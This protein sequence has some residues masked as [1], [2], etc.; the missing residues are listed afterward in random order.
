MRASCF[1][2]AEYPLCQD[3]L[4]LVFGYVEEVEGEVPG[5]VPA[6]EKVGEVADLSGP[7]AS[8]GV[9]SYSASSLTALWLS[10]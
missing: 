6:G 4:A 7:V 10:S 1:S 2:Q 3:F 9:P 8:A 5:A